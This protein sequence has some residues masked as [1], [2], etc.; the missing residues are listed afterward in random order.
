MTTDPTPDGGQRGWPQQRNYAVAD[1]AVIASGVL[2]V[3]AFV[4][5]IPGSRPS[6]FGPRWWAVGYCDKRS[7]RNARP[8]WPRLRGGA[9]AGGA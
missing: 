1:R 7:P 6:P 3:I 8:A 9:G 2:G 5:L 4:L